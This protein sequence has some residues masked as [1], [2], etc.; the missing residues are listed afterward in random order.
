[1]KTITLLGSTGSIG[2]NSLNVI[3]QNNRKFR[4]HGL[5][6]KGM[7]DRFQEQVSEFKPRS[8]CLAE[9]D[10]PKVLLLP[11]NGRVHGGGE[12]LSA[13]A[14]EKSDILI[15]AVVGA[16]GIAPTYHAIRKGRRIALANKESLVA[17][18]TLIMETLKKRGGEIVPIDSEHSAIFQCLLG[19]AGKEIEKI[20]ITASGG[21]FRKMAESD[22]RNVTV[23]D[24]L[25]HPTWSMGPKITIDSATLM[26]KGLEVIEAHFLFNVPFEKIEVVVHPQSL[27]HS[28]VQFVDGS[29][30]AHLGP[31]DM[32][33]PIQYALTY[34]GKIP[35]PGPRLNFPELGNLYFEKPDLNKFPCLGLAFEAGKTGGSLPAVM[36]AAN[37]VAVDRF[38]K[39]R[40]GFTDIPNLIEKAMNA[41]KPLRRYSLEDILAVDAETR[42]KAMEWAS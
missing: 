2:Q 11:R 7:L 25:K 32:K 16:V 41:H 36:N 9:G 21:P 6:T 33:I 29:V 24:A 38:L 27:V 3:R 18:G 28:M 31:P 14:A 5:S 42:K 12:G 19:A 22:L 4:I 17:A 23:Q 30:L 8:V 40:I 10:D 37:E 34:P 1:M 13:L 20:L 26:N 35:M 39:G 15:N